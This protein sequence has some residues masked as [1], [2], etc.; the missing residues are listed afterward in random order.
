MAMRRGRVLRVCAAALVAAAGP[1]AASSF[2]IAPIRIE[3][4]RDHQTGVLTL[5][6]DGDAPVTV[7]V[8]AVAWSQEG[9]D[10]VYQPTRELLVT[11]PV[12][13]VRAQG[14]QIIRV[15]RRAVD[16]KGHE[17]AYRL[18]FQ[19]IPEAAPPG[20][21][22]LRVALRIGVP[23]FIAA[24]VTAPNELTWLARWLED[25]SLR[26]EATNRGLAHVQITEFAVATA[27]DAV[28]ARVGGSRYL[29]AGSHT[30]WTV[31]PV[32]GVDRSGTLRIRGSSD[33]GEIVAD[34]P[35]AAP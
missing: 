3:M 28:I 15:A 4:D 5:H 29:L 11:P 2:N 27:D 7:Q 1:V 22:G 33:R 18:Y 12:F 17:Q 23:V 34:V 35:V 26:L 19:E 13:V 25:G 16:G 21:S 10:D 24:P 8:Q 9:G 31:A 14:D 30:S 6:N 32:A 20:F